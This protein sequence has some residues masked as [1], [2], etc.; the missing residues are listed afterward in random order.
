MSSQTT[1]KKLQELSDS[2]KSYEVRAQRRTFI[3]TLVIPA[4]VL[5][6][7]LFLVVSK[8]RGLNTQVNTLK[9]ELNSLNTSIIE[10]RDALDSVGQESKNIQDELAI[11]SEA[12]VEESLDENNLEAVIGQAI[13]KAGQLDSEI[14]EASNTLESLTITNYGSKGRYTIDYVAGTYNG[15][16]DEECITLE[17]NQLCTQIGNCNRWW[18]DEQVNESS[19]WINGNYLYSVDKDKI[20]VYENGVEIFSDTFK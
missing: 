17:A 2:V 15:C 18:S 19:T 11:I 1:E 4:V 7:Y 13:T 6:A 9:T 10:A 3:F 16:V 14:D 12:I 5:T 20:V 8:V